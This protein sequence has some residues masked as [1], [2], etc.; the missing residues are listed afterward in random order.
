MESHFY[1]LDQQFV[2]MNENNENQQQL[3]DFELDQLRSTL[4][5]ELGEATVAD[6]ENESISP[7][8]FMN[9]LMHDAPRKLKRKLRPEG[10]FKDRLM[11]SLSKKDEN[12]QKQS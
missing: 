7:E 11:K 4:I 12:K 8:Y 6:I 5:E 2:I 10:K 3:D 9:Q 1:P